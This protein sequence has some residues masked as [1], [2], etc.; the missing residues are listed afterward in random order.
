MGLYRQIA[1]AGMPNNQIG[2]SLPGIFDA[3]KEAVSPYI[4]GVQAPAVN[5]SDTGGTTHTTFTDPR[6]WD[7]SDAT[8]PTPID[9]GVIPIQT[10]NP[11]QPLTP[12]TPTTSTPLPTDTNTALK[13]NILPLLALAGVMLVAV[14]GEQLLH[15]NR[16]IALV[17][18]LG[19]LYYGMAKNKLV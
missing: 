2:L 4:E 19:L 8:A 12:D 10:I 18:G 11:S 3:V 5:V 17:G 16:K 6:T 14:T 9:T 7:W 1:G 15:S 13:N